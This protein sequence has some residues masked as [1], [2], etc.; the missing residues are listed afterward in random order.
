MFMPQWQRNAVWHVACFVLTDGDFG[1]PCWYE[2][3]RS[4]SSD[5]LRG[6]DI[7]FP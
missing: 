4:E 5:E 7:C 2:L 6:V 1:G 3:S